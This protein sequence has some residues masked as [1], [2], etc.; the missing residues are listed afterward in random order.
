MKLLHLLSPLT[1]NSKS[2]L[3]SNFEI[4]FTDSYT[5]DISLLL[6]GFGINLA[7][8]ISLTDS[9]RF[10][11]SVLET[12]GLG[13]TGLK[14]S[15]TASFNIRKSAIDVV[16]E[17]APIYLDLR[18]IVAFQSLTSSEGKVAVVKDIDYVSSDGE[19]Q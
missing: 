9:V 15:Q 13:T 10:R 14:K 11:C 8:S 18:K 3:L 4:G 16:T 7:D 2:S 17:I 1:S 6:S 12:I 5:K 19:T